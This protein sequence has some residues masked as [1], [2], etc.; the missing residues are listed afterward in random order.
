[1]RKGKYFLFLDSSNNVRYIVDLS[2]ITTLKESD[3][4]AVEFQIGETEYNVNNKIGEDFKHN[5]IDYINEITE[6]K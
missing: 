5:F 2:K 4:G 3:S 1:M 6:E